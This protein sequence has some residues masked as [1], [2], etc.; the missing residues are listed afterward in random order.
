VSFK[1]LSRKRNWKHREKSMSR[2]SLN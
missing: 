2:S 1:M